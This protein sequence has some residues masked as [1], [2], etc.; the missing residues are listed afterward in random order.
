MVIS[1][2]EAVF[3]KHGKKSSMA[4]RNL[5]SYVSAP[6]MKFHNEQH[7]CTFFHY[8]KFLILN[9]DIF[10]SYIYIKKTQCSFSFQSVSEED[11]NRV[12]YFHHGDAHYVL[13]CRPLWLPNLLW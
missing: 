8:L 12:K 7:R 3:L 11:A 4:K 6:E 9:S 2:T 5:N 13:A 10:I 1:K